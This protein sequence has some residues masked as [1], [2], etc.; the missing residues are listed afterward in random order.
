[1]DRRWK[2]R[3]AVVSAAVVG[4]YLHDTFHAA[5][6]AYWGGVYGPNPLTDFWRRALWAPFG[7]VTQASGFL[8]HVTVEL[9]VV[10]VLTWDLVDSVLAWLRSRRG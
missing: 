10:V 3:F 1:M 9:L 4:Q 6:W 7:E 8:G 5:D 2:V